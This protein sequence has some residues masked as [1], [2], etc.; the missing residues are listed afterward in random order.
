MKY[1]VEV[2]RN[3]PVIIGNDETTFATA[4][5]WVEVLEDDDEMLLESCF[6]LVGD[7]Q[8]AYEFSYWWDMEEDCIYSVFEWAED[9][10]VLQEVWMFR[11]DGTKEQLK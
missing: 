10:P 4:G 8:P 9:G 2:I 11:S 7:E 1:K 6:F 5:K 3:V